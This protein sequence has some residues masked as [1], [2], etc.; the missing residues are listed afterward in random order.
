MTVDRYEL[1]PGYSISRLIHGGWQFSSGHRLTQS[2]LNDAVDVLEASAELGVTTFDCADIY[3]GVE[4]L[5]GR[6][7]RRWASSSND[8]PIQIHTKFVPDWSDLPKVD[9]AYVTRIIDR[10]LARLGVERLDLVQYYWWRDE[11]P[12]FEEAAVWLDD[13]RKQGKIRHVAVTNLDVPRLRRLDQA[14]VSPLT[15]QVQYSLL[16]RRPAGAL[17]ARCSES[18][19]RILGFGALAGGFLTDRWLRQPEPE[20][21]ANRSL[22]KYRLI[23]DEFGGWQA[24]QNLLETMAEIASRRGVETAAVAIRWVLDQ[25]GVAAV[26]A[27]G[28]R[29]GQMA[30]NVAAF[31][32]EFRDED[33]EALRTH[34]DRAPGPTGDVFELE[35]DRDGPHGRIMK[36]DLNRD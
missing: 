8:A 10:S 15:N 32:F 18:V 28:T 31:H 26:I 13:L 11:V 35:S 27:G 23:I 9:R 2:G 3:T 20:G 17:T 21:Y 19:M 34:M 5:Y 24:F 1:S 14:G 12:G 22:V 33:R 30:R 4:E 25:P 29:P 36:Y 16:D 6:F 7:L